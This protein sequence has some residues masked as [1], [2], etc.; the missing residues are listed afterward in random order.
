MVYL[1]VLISFLEDSYS[2]LTFGSSISTDSQ[3]VLLQLM[4]H[5]ESFASEEGLFR[6]PGSHSRIDQ[7]VQQLSTLPLDQVIANPV[8]SPHD[9][10]ST[11]KQFFSELPEPLLLTRHMVAYEQAAGNGIC[12]LASMAV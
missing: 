2:T 4:T 5:L 1:V 8:Y 7:L 10:A 6:K 12:W 3:T 9:Y 11:F